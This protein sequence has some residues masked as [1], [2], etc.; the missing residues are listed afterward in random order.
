MFKLIE[1]LFS[2]KTEGHNRI[3]RFLG[4]RIKIRSTSLILKDLES[5]VFKLERVY[6]MASINHEE[7]SDKMEDFNSSGVT[8][9]PREQKI[10]V[11]LTSYPARMHEI[12]YTIYSLLNQTLKPDA[13]QLWLA[14]EQFPNGEADIPRK[15]RNQCHHGLSIKW[16][17][18][19][20]RSYKKLIPALLEHPNDYIVTADDDLY[21]PENWLEKLW[22]TWENSPKD[23]LV[24]H[25]CHKVQLK[26]TQL[27]TY[28]K[29]PKCVEDCSTS[30]ANFA[31]CGAGTL[32]A[33]GMLHP[34]VTNIALARKLSPHADDAWFWAMAV[35]AGKKTRIVEAP[36]RLIYVNPVREL[37]FTKSKGTLFSYNGAG[38]NDMQISKILAHYPRILENLKAEFR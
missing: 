7:I 25:R 27:A 17:D 18:E 20:W 29:W 11:S 10:I 15:V 13:V 1:R 32:F 37:N 3:I 33:P 28:D 4:A 9:T 35:L 16:C 8:D 30:Y 38:G 21:Y 23:G 31:T 19:D 6:T 34:D 24:A 12:H 14:K 36:Y 26:K 22:V 5:R 2:I